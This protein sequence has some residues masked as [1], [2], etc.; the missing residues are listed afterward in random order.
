MKEKN[1]LKSIKKAVVKATPTHLPFLKKEIVQPRRPRLWQVIPVATLAASAVVIAIVSSTAT[2]SEV[3]NSSSTATSSGVN[4]SSPN[5]RRPVSEMMA[6]LADNSYTLR[7]VFDDVTLYTYEVAETLI[8][9]TF[10]DSYT[11][12]DSSQYL[13]LTDA[14]SPYIYQQID[15]ETWYVSGP[16]PYE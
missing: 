2:P 8:K 15:G 7:Y 13:D 10:P 3:N 9:I 12:S 14:N 6:E 16:Q 5:V 1:I 11:G 4:N